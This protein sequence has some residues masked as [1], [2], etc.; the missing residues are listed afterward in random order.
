MQTAY[1]STGAG[2]RIAKG[3]SLLENAGAGTGVG[4]IGAGAGAAGGDSAKGSVTCENAG[5]A[6]PVR[7]STAEN[8][9]WSS[10]FR[11]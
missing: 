8:G 1:E 3:F 5:G 11:N 6:V 9:F 2:A 4:G 7:S 10:I